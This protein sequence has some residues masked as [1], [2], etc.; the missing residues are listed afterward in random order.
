MEITW[1]L[2]TTAHVD[3]GG[4]LHVPERFTATDNPPDLPYEIEMTIALDGDQ[5][6]CESLTC[7]R[8]EGG[9]PVTSE[10]M[11]QVPVARFLFHAAAAVVRDIGGG[12]GQL[13]SAVGPPPDPSTG[14]TDDVLTYV[15]KLYAFAVLCGQAPTKIVAENIGLPKSTAAYWVSQ[16]RKRGL[17]TVAAP[18]RPKGD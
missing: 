1:D 3:V 5:L 7:R 13:W 4:D 10:G 14:P 15:A 17:L 6:V 2:G 18:R 16:A 11:R 12:G 9:E 8:R